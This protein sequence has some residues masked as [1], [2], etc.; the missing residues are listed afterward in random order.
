MNTICN[1]CGNEFIGI[2]MPDS[3]MCQCCFNRL[4]ELLINKNGTIDILI[5]KEDGCVFNQFHIDREHTIL[6]FESM[7]KL[8]KGG[9]QC[10]N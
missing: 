4:Q 3:T 8:F 5:M 10:S 7:K 1:K 6:I 2:E 9:K